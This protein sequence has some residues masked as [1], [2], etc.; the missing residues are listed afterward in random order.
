M[1]YMRA[2]ASLIGIGCASWLIAEGIYRLGRLIDFDRRLDSIARGIARII[3]KRRIRRSM[4][5][6][7][8][9]FAPSDRLLKDLYD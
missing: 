6:S 2:I 5:E 7:C 9:P 8:M 1:M 4:R 3:L